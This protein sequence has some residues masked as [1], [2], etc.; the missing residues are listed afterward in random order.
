M[1]SDRQLYPAEAARLRFGRTLTAWVNRNGWLHD[2]LHH[3]GEQAGFPA[4]RNSTFNRLQNGKIDQPTPLT[5]YQLGLANAK[6]A[7]GDFAGV[8]KRDLKDRLKDSEAITDAA[9]RPWRAT[10]FFGHFMGEI[11]APSWANH[12]PISDEAAAALS[13]Q[14]AERFAAIAEA[15]G[16]SPGVA[17]RE[18]AK[19][20]GNLSTVQ[21]EL[22]RDVLSGWHAWT[23]EQ[24]EPL[25]ANGS[26]PVADALAAW[27]KG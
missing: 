7:E 5:F 18:L 1:I 12:T 19:H 25:A 4:V 16:I 17:W 20:C 8:V 11:E 14:Q 13:Q 10:E 3:W 21:R 2:T 23:P 6:V 27:E 26:D 9:G 22:L 24:W 15:K